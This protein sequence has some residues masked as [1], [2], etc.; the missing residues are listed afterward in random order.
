M[1]VQLEEKVAA[2]DADAAEHSAAMARL[3]GEK[4][5]LLGLLAQGAAGGDVDTTL[6]AQLGA[7]NA[8]LLRRLSEVCV[9][10]ER[11]VKYRVGV[12]SRVAVRSRCVAVLR[13]VCR[14]HALRQVE[15][16]HAAASD[17]H[18]AALQAAQTQLAAQRADTDASTAA[19]DKIQVVSYVC[20][21]CLSHVYFRLIAMSCALADGQ[22]ALRAEL[23]DQQSAAT[24]LE[25]R[26]AAM[27]S[28]HADADARAVAAAAA[29]QAALDAARGE[30]ARLVAAGEVCGA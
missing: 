7:E 21:N 23:R 20:T 24:A 25:H 29:S 11:D 14:G 22:A 27:A 19:A 26:V 5:Q 9:Y 4:D 3:A 1:T 12:K 15:A 16:A 13:A 30:L 8:A 6:R 17:K 18:H 10:I 28:A 2:L